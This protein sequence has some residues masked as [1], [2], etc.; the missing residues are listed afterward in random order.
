MDAQ[1]GFWEMN[2]PEGGASPGMEHKALRAQAGSRI[3]DNDDP[4]SYMSPQSSQNLPDLSIP[5]LFP[6]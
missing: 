5:S 2:T 6:A 1:A 3:Y 4:A